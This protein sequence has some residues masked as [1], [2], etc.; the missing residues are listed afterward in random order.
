MECCVCSRDFTTRRKPV[1]ASCAQAVLHGPRIKQASALLDR[2]KQHTHAEAVLRPGNDGVIAALPQD[3]DYD[4]IGAGIKKHAVQK[5]RDERQVLE[6]RISDITEKAHELRKQIE[7]YKECAAKQRE[8]HVRRRSDL[9]TEHKQ[10]EKQRPRALD[11]VQTATLKAQQR[12]EKVQNRTVDARA[13]LCREAALLAGLQKRRGANGKAE[14][15]LGGA[16]VPNLRELHGKAMAETVSDLAKVEPPVHAHELIS[17][18]LDNVCRLLGNCCHYLSV[19]LPAEILL[20]HNG[21]AHARI[22]SEKYSYKPSVLPHSGMHSSQIANS[23][24]SQQQRDRSGRPRSLYLAIPLAHLLKDDS[25]AFQMFVE[26]VTYLAYNIAWLCKS[27]GLDKITSFEDV[28]AVGKNLYNLLLA[29]EQ[30]RS[31]LSRNVSS[32]TPRTDRSR[33]FTTA[34]AI[35]LGAYSHASA[36]HSLSSA[37]A[38]ELFR[39]CRLPPVIRLTDALKAYLVNEISGAEWDYM[40]GEEWNEEREDEVPVLVGGARRSLDRAGEPAMSVMSIAPQDGASEDVGKKG[41]SGWMKLRGRGG[42]G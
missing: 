30:V 12:L 41:S 1:C 22:L 26:G 5:A 33:P 40:S 2:E 29:Q 31:P 9:A 20:P 6:A 17:A 4:A 13:L 34:P 18:G 19:R 7:D 28:C 15:W 16:P 42:E 14:Y 32:A 3:A 37:A 25:N 11:P 36:H 38:T 10:L 8:H 39:S 27:Q 21:V 35:R 23:A 24:P